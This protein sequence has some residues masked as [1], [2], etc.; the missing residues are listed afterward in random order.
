[1]LKMKL[2][3][4]MLAL[5]F[6]NYFFKTNKYGTFSAERNSGR[7]MKDRIVRREKRFVSEDVDDNLE[8]GRKDE[9]DECDK[10]RW[11]HFEFLGGSARA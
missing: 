8:K 2:V 10:V 11:R 5:N 3:E 4:G 9:V 6:F 1:M 7:G